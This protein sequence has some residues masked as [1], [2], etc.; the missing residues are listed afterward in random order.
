MNSSNIEF[1]EWFAPFI[2]PARYKVA[3][4]GRGTAKS[5]SFGRYS[6]VKAAERKLRI[7]CARELQNSI[8]DSVHQL[9][10]SQIEMMGLQ[11]WFDIGES[12]IRSST[13][14]EY[15]FKGLRHNAGEIKS[16]EGIDICWVE[17][18]A[19]VSE[20]SWNILI[21]T[22]RTTGSEIWVSFNTREE[23][24]PTYQRFVKEPPPGAV[25]KKV[26]WWENPWMSM[27]L[28]AERQ[29]LRRVDPVAY[30]N[31]WGGDPLVLSDS[32]VLSGKYCSEP[33]EPVTRQ[34][35]DDEHRNWD[36]PYYG[37]D[38]GFSV[39]PTVMTKSWIYKRVLYVEE[40]AYRVGLE[41]DHTPEYFRR[42]CPGSDKAISRADNARPET[43]SHMRR[44]GYP[45]MRG[46]EKWS[47][48]VKDGV[49]YLRAFER[50]VIH[51]RC[52]HTLD[53]ANR[54][55]YKRD[56]LTQEVLPE[57]EDKHN[58]CW[59]SI[60]YALDKHIRRKGQLLIG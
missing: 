30:A 7:L 8:K 53:E 11:G 13:G 15:I 56:R 21:P 34:T 54:W 23:R 52:Q 20:E 36:G 16:L 35:G 26:M 28:E 38:W 49:A 58:H 47:G 32:L 10:R 3:Y 12:Y 50:I 22:I 60:R 19:N 48:S 24:D 39:D 29:Y 43:I 5:W 2:G 14:S 41:L 57:L 9:L 59:D 44:N 17:E 42:H 31:V 25:V 37:V 18:A 51:P 46:C 27:E 33:F 1:P 45:Y 4:G 40:E 6:L 55:S